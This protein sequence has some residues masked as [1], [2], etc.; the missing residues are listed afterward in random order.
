L[1][2]ST[3]L[4]LLTVLLRI[5]SLDG[6]AQDH[7][8]VPAG[9][10][11]RIV[12]FAD[13]QCSFCAR[14]APEL[15][16][17]Q[18]EYPGRVTVVFK[19]FPL[20]IHARARA[21]H[22]AALAAGEQDRF[23]EMHDLIYAHPGHLSAADFDHYADMLGLD[24]DRFHAA[25]RS[26]VANTVIETDI[27]EGKKLGISATPTLLVDGHR[28]EGAQNYA[29]LKR[30]TESELKGEK[31]K[32]EAP[33]VFAP[34]KVNTDG[35]PSKGELSA[36]VTIVEFSDFQCPFCAKAVTPL[37]GIM[38]GQQGNLRWVFKNFP[39][40]NHA[41]APLAHRAALAAGEQGK[42]WEMHDLI[43]AH[44]K[45]I[46]RAH[47]LSL[48][49]QLNL[50]LERFQKDLDD[51]RLEARIQADRNEGVKAGVQATPTFVIN[52]E[53]VSGFSLPRFQEIVRRQLANAVSP[54]P[55]N[56]QA[57]LPDLD[58]TLGPQDAPIKIEWFADLGS[59]LTARSAF[60]LQQFLSTHGGVV[61]VQFRN[62]PLP[63]RDVSMLL[64]EFALA[65]AVQ[66]KFWAAE[67]LLLADDKPKD[68]KELDTLALQLGLDRN[69]LW[70]EIEA[71][72]HVPY[73]TRD[74]LLAKEI[75]VTGTPTF[76]VDGRK[77]DG[78]NGL[79]LL[80]E[81]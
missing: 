12:E 49:S 34:V 76:V 15:R 21:A 10:V 31:W 9:P 80:E 38:A 37:E 47:L 42:F 81:K 24:K 6:T 72:T 18:A 39:L 30:M 77:L 78:V 75:G 69:R 35:A 5:L 26:G 11:V 79:E 41:D 29:A 55:L 23:W 36:P 54:G 74:L 28:I 53:V 19:N 57:S 70:R 14:Q 3:G 63:H 62:F 22:Q 27:A 71:G 20:P 61:R 68:R 59:P 58:L 64:H 44:Q 40:G 13:F 7:A 32:I 17:L 52:G 1:K 43:F 8:A 51:P 33:A 67:A 46:K 50:D 45:T 25:L 56:P 65:A 73:I 4:I 48:A 16:Q 66:G 2:P 60:A